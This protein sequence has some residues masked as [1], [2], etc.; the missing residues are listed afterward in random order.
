M[1]GEDEVSDGDSKGKTLYQTKEGED[2]DPHGGSGLSDRGLMNG[3]EGGLA[4]VLILKVCQPFSRLGSLLR[5]EGHLFQVPLVV[6][7][8]SV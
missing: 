4:N 5:G 2:V 1:S 7:D 3:G 8:D 6:L